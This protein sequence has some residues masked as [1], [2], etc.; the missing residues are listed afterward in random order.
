MIIIIVVI[1]VIIMIIII[2]VIIVTTVILVGRG[3]GVGDRASAELR[4]R[5]VGI[6]ASR[7]LGN[8]LCL[9]ALGLHPLNLRICLSQTL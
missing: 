2:I 6:V 3:F 9:W 1:I 5:K 8:S 7:F 4:G